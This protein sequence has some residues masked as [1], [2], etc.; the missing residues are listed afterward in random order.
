MGIYEIQA[1]EQTVYFCKIKE[2]CLIFVHFIYID[3]EQLYDINSFKGRF[4]FV[5]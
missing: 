4:I 1:F 5:C 2:F 3:P